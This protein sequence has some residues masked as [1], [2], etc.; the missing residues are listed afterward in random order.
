MKV[1]N[2]SSISKIYQHEFFL[3]ISLLSPPFDHINNKNL[4]TFAL[5]DFNKE[6]RYEFEVK[7]LPQ[8]TQLLLEKKRYD[9]PTL[10][11][12]FS[13]LELGKNAISQDG[14]RLVLTIFE[15][16][17][18]ALIGNMKRFIGKN[19]VELKS[20]E[21]YL[22]DDFEKE[23]QINPYLILVRRYL[24]FFYQRSQ[25]YGKLFKMF[26]FLLQDFT[27]N[28]FI[29][30]PVLSM[31][32][33]STNNAS[34]NAFQNNI[35]V[36]KPHIFQV[37]FLV[38]H[39]LHKNYESDTK[40]TKSDYLMSSGFFAKSLYHFF[41]NVLEVW[42]NDVNNNSNLLS[43]LGKVW[44]SFLKPWEIDD[45]YC[46]VNYLNRIDEGKHVENICFGSLIKEYQPSKELS[47]REN[48]QFISHF[49]KEN[50]LFYTHVFA[51][52]LHTLSEQ[53]EIH[54]KDLIFL[55][56][57]LEF[58]LGNNNI[59]PPLN[60]FFNGFIKVNWIKQLSTGGNNKIEG[61]LDVMQY[62]DFMGSKL[63]NLN[64]FNDDAL[65]S[66]VLKMISNLTR[67]ETAFKKKVQFLNLFIFK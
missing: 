14:K 30:S 12:Y 8:N 56:N 45:N 2:E 31:N 22:C 42:N 17:I 4:F 61:T 57:L 52:F 5:A 1:S 47:K 3:L 43:D 28:D 46:I 44:I 53:N 41:T 64:L 34:I 55:Q 48:A 39:Y 67:Y 26:L 58:F 6:R 60:S 11:G 7:R 9:N 37:V 10:I 19:H 51:Q 65:L 63:H 21:D 49:L 35:K 38:I 29:Y 20:S 32:R 13:F 40:T 15:F 27:I 23:F 59:K 54:F 66:R 50:V 18:F 33:Y 25:K 36:P 16:Y 62:L 24:E